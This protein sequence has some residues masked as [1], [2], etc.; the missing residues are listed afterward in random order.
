MNRFNALEDR[1]ILEGDLGFR[2]QLDDR[3]EEALAVGGLASS[4]RAFLATAIR[5]QLV[6]LLAPAEQLVGKARQW[7]EEA[8]ERR[9]RPARYFPHAS[10]AAIHRTVALARWLADGTHDG[11]NLVRYADEQEVYLTESGS[12]RDKV[13]V[14]LSLPG[15][16]DAERFETALRLI[17]GSRLV[18]ATSKPASEEAVMAVAVC[19]SRLNRTVGDQELAR[20]VDECV[21]SHIHRW[22]SGGH[23]LRVGE[24][25]KILFW[26]SAE[27]PTA[28]IERM[29]TYLS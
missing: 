7:A 3:F 14:R 11:V 15:F 22:L 9:E 8:L 26:R 27:M 17:D 16:V 19:R 10:E 18:T 2:A 24:W 28:A 13:S 21:G 23:A 6:G 29:R 1:S 4:A 12:A 5:C 20:T 25:A